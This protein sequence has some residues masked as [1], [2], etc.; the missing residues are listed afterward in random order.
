MESLK[1]Y[2]RVA[3]VD[4]YVNLAV[5][6][7]FFQ[8]W[9][10]SKQSYVWLKVD[11]P[12]PIFYHE[13]ETRYRDS[14]LLE[15]V[16]R[17]RRRSEGIGG[18]KSKG[19]VTSKRVGYTEEFHCYIRDGCGAAPA[20]DAAAA[21]PRFPNSDDITRQPESKDGPLNYNVFIMAFI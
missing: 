18:E 21:T 2:F 12:I 9:E 10:F 17:G 8:N 14:K 15:S 5:A 19:D 11:E 16:I 7:W 13:L 20:A 3:V 4:K 1:L 6:K